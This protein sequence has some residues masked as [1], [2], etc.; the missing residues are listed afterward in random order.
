LSKWP[1]FSR[2][3]HQNFMCI[4]VLPHKVPRVPPILTSQSLLVS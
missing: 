4:C 3:L 1:P 2:F